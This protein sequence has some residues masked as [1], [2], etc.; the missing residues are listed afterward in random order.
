MSIICCGFLLLIDH[1]SSLLCNFP[2]YSLHWSSS[3]SPLH[4]SLSLFFPGFLPPLLC[5]LILIS[6]FFSSSLRI[7]SQC[8]RGGEYWRK[9]GSREEGA[10][11]DEG[12]DQEKKETRPCFR[13]ALFWRCCSMQAVATKYGICVSHG[14]HL[15]MLMSSDWCHLV[16]VSLLMPMRWC[17]DR[18][19]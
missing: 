18:Y 4:F 16:D 6:D 11:D 7:F 12:I 13:C 17:V 9:G 19:W 10:G 1:S 5:S 2:F 15:L 14:G 3:T 8:R